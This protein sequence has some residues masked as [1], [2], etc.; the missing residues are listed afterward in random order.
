MRVHKAIGILLVL[1]VM[2]GCR[3]VVIAPAAHF[4]RHWGSYGT[5]SGYTSGFYSVVH[6]YQ[7]DSTSRGLSTLKVR[8][9]YFHGTNIPVQVECFSST[10]VMVSR[11]HADTVG[12]AIKLSPGFYT[13]TACIHPNEGCISADITI[14]EKARVSLYMEH[15]ISWVY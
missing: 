7:D 15:P 9:I 4:P 3:Q 11:F 14:P 5:G 10:G 12:T 2:S 8:C 6:E 1:C 13:I